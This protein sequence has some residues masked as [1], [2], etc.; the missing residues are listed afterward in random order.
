MDSDSR[1]YWI[2]TL[3]LIF[4]AAFFALAETAISSVSKNRIRTEASRGDPRAE[5]ALYVLDHFE[6]AITTLLICTNIVH[7]ST[8]ALVTV[9]VTKLWGLSAVSLS[10]VITTI[11]VFFA[12]EM[13]PKS[14]AKKKPMQFTLATVGILT[15]LMKVLSPFSMILSKIGRFVS[16]KIS[17]EQEVSVTEEELYDIIEDMNEEG[18]ID[19]QQAGLLS[20][21]LRFS[22]KTA[23]DIMTPMDQVVAV[24]ISD[25][26]EKIL[27]VIRS[28]NHSRVPV[29]RGDPDHIIGVLQIRKVLKQWIMNEKLP[30]ILPLLDRVYFTGPETEVDELLERMSGQKVTM[31]VLRESGSGGKTL[32]I[33]S[34]EDILEELVGEIYDEDDRRPAAPRGKQPAE[35][36]KGGVR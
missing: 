24:N 18:S 12:G 11:V 34:V 20:S 14:I 32:G 4:F 22:K 36:L 15:V 2:I 8:A 35:E 29:Y 3:F 7:I 30:A 26:P 6:N 13:L 25:G 33:V 9:A 1:S 27:R 21:A 28:Q 10:T 5:K 17:Q 19:D 31:A 23:F 16:K